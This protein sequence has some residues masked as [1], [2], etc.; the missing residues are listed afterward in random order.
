MA[1]TSRL[2]LVGATAN[3]TFTGVFAPS[4]A[5]PPTAR[6]LYLCR[7]SRATKA[8]RGT[9]AQ[10]RKQPHNGGQISF[11]AQA[12]E[13]YPAGEGPAEGDRCAS[14]PPPP[15]QQPPWGPRSSDA[16]WQEVLHVICN[17]LDPSSCRLLDRNH[18]TLIPALLGKPDVPPPTH[19]KKKIARQHTSGCSKRPR[20]GPK[21]SR[22]CN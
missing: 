7:I 11:T 5:A 20:N 16:R 2:S 4:S 22:A 21:R 6:A 9:I 12:R 14:V 18:I 15:R 3:G 8:F 13:H 19:T 17:N 1:G 10:R